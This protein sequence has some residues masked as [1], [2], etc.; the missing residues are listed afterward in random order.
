MFARATAATF[1]LR[2][3]ISFL[4]QLSGSALFSA[5]R[6]T[7]LAPCISRVRRYVRHAC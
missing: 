6:M 1:L 3:A 2:L 5:N 4:I 7:A